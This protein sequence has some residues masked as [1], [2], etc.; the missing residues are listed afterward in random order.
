MR[1]SAA[2]LGVLFAVTACNDEK[3]NRPFSATP[4]DALFN[5]YVSMGNS[6][7]AGFQSGGINDSTQSQSYAVLLAR[8]MHAPFF[9]PLMNKPGCPPPYTN[10]FTQTRLGGGAAPPCALRKTQ[11]IPPPFISNTAVPG[12]RVNDVYE[13]V[14]PT[15]NQLT[16]FFLGGLTQVQMARRAAPTF[17]S[18]WIGNNDV[19][20]A[21]T[22]S[23]NAGDTTLITP[24][25]VFQAR[26]DSL[27][28]SVYVGMSPSGGILV[29]VANV[30]RI[31]YFSRG[32][33]Y[34]A[35]KAGLVPNAAFPP[36]FVVA[37]NCAPPRGDS[38]LVP[39]PYGLPK[40]DSAAA[41]PAGT[42]TLDC[43]VPQ[44]V[45]PEELVRLVGA[46]TA[47]NAKISG[48]A[49][50]QGWAYLDPNPVFD[51]IAL[52]GSIPAFPFAKRFDTGAINSCAGAP[53]KTTPPTAPATPPPFG[54]MFSCDG[55]HPTA[56]AH[57]LIAQH[58][59]TAVN[60]AYTTAI[61]AI[62]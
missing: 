47:Y 26:S 19:L 42:F 58:I 53:A 4:V 32:S 54:L 22:S 30:T 39:F 23:A 13:N 55:V 52:A 14:A 24:I 25:P 46:V 3:L 6:I 18:V 51:S 2:V 31:P 37:A 8:A 21:A 11:A 12:A 16:Q 27:I 34:F 10:V 59:R 56:A 41:I 60:T 17:L 5:R 49:T 29:G 61:P 36:N 45:V 40:I 20:G 38:V 33:T 57:R 43:S 7:T 15:A 44:V 48:V 62:P 35:I 50:A 9:T 1:L 28:D